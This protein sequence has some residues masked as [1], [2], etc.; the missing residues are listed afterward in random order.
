MV[1]GG[2]TSRWFLIYRN[3]AGAPDPYPDYSARTLGGAA[4]APLPIMSFPGRNGG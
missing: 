3:S 1:D 4:E 2:G